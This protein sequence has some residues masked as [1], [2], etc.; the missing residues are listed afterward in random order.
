MSPNLLVANARLVADLAKVELSIRRYRSRFRI[1]CTLKL[2]VVSGRYCSRFC[3]GSPHCIHIIKT[4]RNAG[5][6]NENLKIFGHLIKYSNTVRNSWP[7]NLW[8]CAVN[9]GWL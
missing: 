4:N 7:G 9:H 8:D 6:I 5:D 3:I 1:D 2:R